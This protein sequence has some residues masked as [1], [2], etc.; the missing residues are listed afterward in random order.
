[1]LKIHHILLTAGLV[2]IVFP[3]YASEPLVQISGDEL[4]KE[5]EQILES[6]PSAEK[7]TVRVEV[8]PVEQAL[9]HSINLE[10]FDSNQDGVFERDEIGE[11]LFRLFDRDGNKV[12][13]NIEMKRPRIM[14]FTPMER[15][16]MEIV[17]YRTDDKPVKETVSRQEFLQ[18]SGLSRFDEGKDGLSPLDFIGK[19]FYQVNVHKDGVIDMY[20]WKRAYAEMVR[21]MHME[22]FNYN[23]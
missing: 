17:E 10:K 6:E 3:A 12:I 22:A 16:T 20:E 7:V 14:T 15:K 21:P 23:D 18:Q 5:A 19:S 9:P 13:D 8:E 11:T 4:Q 2:S 1:M